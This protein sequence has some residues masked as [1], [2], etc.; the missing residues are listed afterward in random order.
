MLDIEPLVPVTLTL[1]LPTLAYSHVK[2]T[3][4]ERTVV[5]K[6]TLDALNEHGVP[7]F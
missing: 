3:E 2:V 5:L 7:P 6:V 1:L 4:P